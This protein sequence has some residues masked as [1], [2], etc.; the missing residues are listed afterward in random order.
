MQ[1]LIDMRT[2]Y[3]AYDNAA[4][5]NS[6]AL[7]MVPFINPWGMT[8]EDE[9][10]AMKHQS[11]V[12][13]WQTRNL[14]KH[15]VVQRQHWHRPINSG[16]HPGMMTLS[17]KRLKWHITC[18]NKEVMNAKAKDYS[19]CR[20]IFH[21]C[22]DDYSESLWK[23]INH[24]QGAIP[25]C[26]YLFIHTNEFSKGIKKAKA[27]LFMDR[28]MKWSTPIGC[29]QKI[30]LIMNHH[31]KKRQMWQNKK[32]IVVS[33]ANNE[34]PAVHWR[35]ECRWCKWCTSTLAPDGIRTKHLF[36]SAM[37]NPLIQFRD[38]FVKRYAVNCFR[39]LLDV[40]WM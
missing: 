6:Q 14:M 24:G 31:L 4:A 20:D 10:R 8:T 26:L 3:N 27:K 13:S 7:S 17:T 22:I 11:P 29:Q 34:G 5:I 37:A 18:P 30:K 19:Y 23:L 28:W 15:V 35:S 39:H 9:R 33:I 38:A 16:M 32:A 1:A 36:R 21:E 12:H 25:A 40:A 2:D